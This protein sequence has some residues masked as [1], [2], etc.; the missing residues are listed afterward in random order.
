MPEVNISSG[1]VNANVRAG[2]DIDAS[3]VWKYGSTENE[4]ILCGSGEEAD[5]KSQDRKCAAFHGRSPL[6]KVCSKWDSVIRAM[7]C[8]GVPGEL[9]PPTDRIRVTRSAQDTRPG[10]ANRAG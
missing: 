4:V 5:A 8:C 6:D 2:E 7:L 9:S 1:G 10:P 3:R